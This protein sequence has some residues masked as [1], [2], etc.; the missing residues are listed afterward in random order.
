MTREEFNTRVAAHTGTTPFLMM[1]ATCPVCRMMRPA[2][3]ELIARM[4]ASVRSIETS[5]AA[6]VELSR[7]L[8]VCQL[9][10]ILIWKDGKQIHAS[11][12]AIDVGILERKLK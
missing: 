7:Y 10:L 9:P 1:A 6:S 5:Q 8:G 3:Y 12:G 4:R 11:E 2:L